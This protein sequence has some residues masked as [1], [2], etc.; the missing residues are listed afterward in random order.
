MF[1]CD[2]YNFTLCII[3]YIT[4]L[5]YVL[6]TFLLIYLPNKIVCVCNRY[7]YI[8]IRLCVSQMQPILVCVK[9]YHWKVH[10]FRSY[11]WTTIL[12]NS[13]TIT[14]HASLSICSIKYINFVI[15]NINQ[16]NYLSSITMVTGVISQCHIYISHAGNHQE[17]PGQL[18]IVNWYVLIN[19][20]RSR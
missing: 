10:L 19:E 9:N 17:E 1:K 6:C 13:K 3:L 11:I 5:Y 16:N 4:Y 7:I 20:Y 8:Y 12:Y 18:F 2:I 15:L 14:L